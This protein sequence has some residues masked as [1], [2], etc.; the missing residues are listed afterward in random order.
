MKLLTHA[1][2]AQLLENGAVRRPLRGPSTKS[3]FVP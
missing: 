2:F 1:Q 3:T